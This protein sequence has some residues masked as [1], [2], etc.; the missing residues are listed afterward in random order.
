MASA[1]VTTLD[2]T[3]S[4]R[5]LVTSETSTSLDGHSICHDL[6]LRCSTCQTGAL[7]TASILFAVNGAVQNWIPGYD[8][9][10]EDLDM[11]DGLVR[12]LQEHQLTVLFKIQKC[13][14]PMESL[15]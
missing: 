12:V 4:I 7:L 11:G 13:F 8:V 15:R 9:A 10:S 14:F 5:I 6:C 2:R 1:T 3:A